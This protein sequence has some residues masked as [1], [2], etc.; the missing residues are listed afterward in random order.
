MY[1]FV[2]ATLC[3]HSVHALITYYQFDLAV[4]Y[5]GEMGE[6]TQLKFN[7]IFRKKI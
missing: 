7:N 5:S 1:Y 6:N 2:L 3:T 4:S